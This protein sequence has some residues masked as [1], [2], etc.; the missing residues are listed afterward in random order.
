[1]KILIIHGPNLNL[2]G[3]RDKSIYGSFTLEEINNRIKL[4][5]KELNMEVELFQSNSEEYY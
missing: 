1:M 4:K 3:K 5:S 2:L